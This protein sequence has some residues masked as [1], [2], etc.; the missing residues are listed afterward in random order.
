MKVWS[1]ELPVITTLSSPPVRMEVLPVETSLIFI[2][3]PERTAFVLIVPVKIIDCPV[4]TVPVVIAIS[5]SKPV[6]T[7]PASLNFLTKKTRS[8]PEAITHSYSPDGILSKFV[9]IHAGAFA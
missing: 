9:H 8:K 5:F 3:S 6:P 4:F 1:N 7:R 2:S